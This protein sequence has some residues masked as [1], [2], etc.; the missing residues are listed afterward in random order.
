MRNLF[1]LFIAIPC[2][3]YSQNYSDYDLRIQYDIN[4]NI[5][6]GSTQELLQDAGLS[7]IGDGVYAYV[8]YV[9]GCS[10]S[11][12]HSALGEARNEIRLAG[13]NIVESA[14]EFESLRKGNYTKVYSS[15]DCYM[16]GVEYYRAHNR[17]GSIMYRK[18]DVIYN[19]KQLKDHLDYG[20]I[21]QAQYNQKIQKWRN[22]Y[23][24][25]F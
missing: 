9:K 13:N 10:D 11:R 20:I 14:T 17:D 22:L 23:N 12:G 21:T 8:A 2:L 18:S 1:Y 6:I 19:M 25:M 4:G 24:R 5:D 16:K 7:Y 3:M 15:N